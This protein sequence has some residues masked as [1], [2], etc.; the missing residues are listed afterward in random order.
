M[1][2]EIR[3]AL[4]HVVEVVFTD[5]D[6]RAHRADVHRVVVEHSRNEILRDRVWTRSQGFEPDAESLPAIESLLIPASCVAVAK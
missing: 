4:D 2:R 3:A 5:E 1:A 6:G